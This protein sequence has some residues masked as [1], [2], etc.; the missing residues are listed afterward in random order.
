MKLLLTA[1]AA[2]AFLGAAPLATAKD[3]DDYKGPYNVSQDEAIEIAR[4]N[5]MV[6]IWET[7]RDDGLWE[8][9]GANA[10][11]D[12]LEIEISGQTG[13]LLKIETEFR[14]T[15]HHSHHGASDDSGHHSGD[16]H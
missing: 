14:G 13:E 16:H 3:R 6:E 10:D 12:K 8:I 7:E 11:G 4:A 2:S 9:E 15:G 1:I 5:G